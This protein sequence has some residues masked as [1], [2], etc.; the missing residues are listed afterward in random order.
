MKG[1]GNSGEPL[2]PKRYTNYLEISDQLEQRFALNVAKATIKIQLSN[3]MRE[4][5]LV[6][7][8]ALGR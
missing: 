7:R 2:S 5:G 8:Y 1:G 4:V 6:R 3:Y